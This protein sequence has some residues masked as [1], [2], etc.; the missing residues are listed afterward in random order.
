M[1]EKMSDTAKKLFNDV[2]N[3]ERRYEHITRLAREY[4]TAR[5]KEESRFHWFEFLTGVVVGVAC[6]AIAV[7]IVHIL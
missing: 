4:E 3:M 6:A 1:G 5:Y 2:R 7:A